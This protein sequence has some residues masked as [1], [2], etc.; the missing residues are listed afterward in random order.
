MI[1]ISLKK[2]FN[3]LREEMINRRAQSTPDTHTADYPKCVQRAQA[4]HK[5]ACMNVSFNK[6]RFSAC[7]CVPLRPFRL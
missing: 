5:V 7:V 2:L 6:S 3:D 4:R 1:E